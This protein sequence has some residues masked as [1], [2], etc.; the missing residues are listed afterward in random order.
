MPETGRAVPD[1]ARQALPRPACSWASRHGP[2]AR[3]RRAPWCGPTPRKGRD[4]AG[5]H[6]GRPPVRQREQPGA[7]RHAAR[8]RRGGAQH[9]EQAGFQV[10]ERERGDRTRADPGTVVEPDARRRE[11]PRLGSTVQHRRR[12]RT[13][14]ADPDTDADRRPTPRRAPDATGRGTADGWSG[15]PD[16]AAD[17]SGGHAD[18]RGQPF[19][20]R[21]RVGV[22]AGHQPVGE[23][24]VAALG[25]HRLGVEL[26]ALQREVAVAQRHDDA[27]L[28][29]AGDLQLGGQASPGRRPA[30]GSG[31][32]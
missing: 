8:Q 28:G 25:Q 18:D 21:R 6:H 15:R 29:A 5:R 30:S 11:H 32:R 17:R 2:V 4:R 20:A 31:S 22:A 13:A 27:A 12:H 9:L 3:T 26:H 19:G 14:G 24:P 16:A 10:G 23:H 7:R 1:E